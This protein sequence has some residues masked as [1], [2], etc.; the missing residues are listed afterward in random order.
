MA[1]E[2]WEYLIIDDSKSESPDSEKRLNDVGMQGWG[3]CAIR[4]D[5][6]GVSRWYFKRRV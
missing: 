6:H 1:K 2:K 5:R 3:L 4:L